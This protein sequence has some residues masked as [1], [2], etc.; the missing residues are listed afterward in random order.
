MKIGVGL[1]CIQHPNSGRQQPIDGAPQII[2][3]DR[4]VDGERGHLGARMDSGVRAS[5]SR[6]MNRLAF[7]G[8]DDFFKNPLDGGKA[9]LYLPAV[10]L[11]PSQASV[12]RMRRVKSEQ[13]DS[14]ADSKPAASRAW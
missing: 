4:I 1:D 7:D 3:R 5:R 13:A 8:A 6:D 10:E 11:V 14:P 2:R 12:M 9:G